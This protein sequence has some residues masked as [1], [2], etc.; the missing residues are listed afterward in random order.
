LASLS[1]SR[2]PRRPACK[3]RFS[4]SSCLSRK[5]LSACLI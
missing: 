2:I 4:R 5:F 3:T 1:T